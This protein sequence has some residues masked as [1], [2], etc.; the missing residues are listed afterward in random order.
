MDFFIEYILPILI[1]GFI[2]LFTNYLAIIMLFRP[3]KEIR[4][5]KCKL[6]FTPGLIPKEKDKIAESLSKTITK[7]FLNKDIL[8]KYIISKEMIIKLED[9]IQNFLYKI[10]KEEY[11][12]NKFLLN[13]TSQ[14]SVENFLYKSKLHIG[15]I[16]VDKFKEYDLS[17]KISKQIVKNFLNSNDSTLTKAISL[18]VNEKV[19]KNIE[20]TISE[21]ISQY[22]EKDGKN[23]IEILFYNEIKKLLN[24]RV[25]EFKKIDI[26]NE[27]KTKKEII[28]IY[29]IGIENNIEK[30]LKVIDFENII[31]E[32]IRSLDMKDFEKMIKEIAKKELQAITLLGGLLGALIGIINVII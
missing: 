12:I 18:F 25:G 28:R 9:G 23:E 10:E 13:Y 24:K 3:Y 6:P 14:G 4:I 8:L 16:F 26:L 5:F 31:F 32:R 27:E 17:N 15:N 7:E 30:L 19:S 2:G 22:I 20:N 21:K 1:A 11:S 29:K